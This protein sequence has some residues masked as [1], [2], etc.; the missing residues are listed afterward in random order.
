MREQSPTGGHDEE[1][2]WIFREPDWLT[3]LGTSRLLAART[4]LRGAHPYRRFFGLG[5]YHPEGGTQKNN[6][7]TGQE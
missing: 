5:R 6:Y 3:E 7:C 1:R 4:L 2:P